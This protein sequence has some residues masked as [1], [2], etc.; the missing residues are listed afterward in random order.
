MAEPLDQR[1]TRLRKPIVHFD[2]KI[3]QLLVPKKPKALTKLAKPP[4]QSTKPA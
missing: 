3:A 1:S 2:N 4:T